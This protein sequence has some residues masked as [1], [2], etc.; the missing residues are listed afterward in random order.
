[1]SFRA[2]VVMGFKKN[3]RGGNRLECLYPESSCHSREFRPTSAR[4]ALRGSDGGMESG[5]VNHVQTN[6][7]NTPGDRIADYCGWE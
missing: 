4:P 5:V 2:F 7:K 1:M 6:V 3:G